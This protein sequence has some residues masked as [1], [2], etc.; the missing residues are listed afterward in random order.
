MIA[1]FLPYVPQFR[2]KLLPVFGC[3]LVGKSKPHCLSQKNNSPNCFSCAVYTAVGN[4]LPARHFIP[5]VACLRHRFNFLGGVLKYGQWPRQCAPHGQS[6]QHL[7]KGAMCYEQAKRAECYER[8]SVI[9][10]CRYGERGVFM[11]R[12]RQSS[13][14][15]SVFFCERL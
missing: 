7:R 14:I 13:G 12:T 6:Q 5:P 9:H 4:L 1:N 3:R 8:A 11:R 10:L 15:G 2:L